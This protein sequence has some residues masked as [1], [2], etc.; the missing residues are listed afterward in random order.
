MIRGVACQA[1]SPPLIALP[2]LF[3]RSRLKATAFFSR[4]GQR[5]PVTV[6]DPHESVAPLVV[7][8]GEGRL[9]RRAGHPGSLQH[10]QAHSHDRALHLGVPGLPARISQWEVGEHEPG[11]SAFLDDIAGRAH[12]HGGHT[13]L[14]EVP[15]DQTHG[16]VTDRSERREEHGFDTIL[17]APLQDLRGVAQ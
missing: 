1:N 3:L 8:P 2:L 16:L 15:G 13:V 12:Y 11:D 9:N 14:F 17:T 4:P 7:A 5:F 6:V 10:I